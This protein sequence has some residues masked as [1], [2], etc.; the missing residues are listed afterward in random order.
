[1]S[2]HVGLGLCIVAAGMA[3]WRVRGLTDIGIKAGTFILVSLFML[4][5][6]Y[7]YRQAGEE[8]GI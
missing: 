3:I 1:V 7:W 2:R 5:V 6:A 8:A 4:A